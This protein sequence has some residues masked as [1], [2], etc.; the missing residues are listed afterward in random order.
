MKFNYQARTKEGEIKIGI[1]EASSRE[2]ALTILQRAG[3]YVT[4]LKEAKPPLYARQIRIFRAISI[5]DIVLFSRQLAIMFASKVPLLEALRTLATQTANSE[6]R[7]K[8]FDLAKEVEGGSSLSKALSRHPKIFSPFFISIVK[9]GEASGKLAESLTYLADHLEREY[10][11]RNRIRGAMLY[12]ALVLVVIFSVLTLIVFLVVPNFERVIIE[13]G[14]EAPKIT[15]L[16]IA[17]S[18]FFRKNF[19]FI[20]LSLFLLFFIVSRYYK[21]KEGKILFDK[22][23]L[24][25]PELGSL[26]K[27]LYVSRFAENL[28]TLISAGILLPQAL[29]ITAEIVGNSLYKAA[30]LSAKEETKKGIPISSALAMFPKIF[31]PIFIEMASVGEKT[32]TLDTTLMK[33][34]L[35]YRKEME[36]T[37][38]SL[39]GV[40]EPVLIII[41]G[42]VVGGIVASVLLPLYQMLG[43]L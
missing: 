16:V 22:Y 2:A 5:R 7:E 29:E 38:E 15:Q 3:F 12:P 43:P 13:S 14:I 36:R 21:T 27:T 32:G 11:L 23:L 26:L 35:F 10:D 1:V 40:L 31:P 9:S 25:I 19:L 42:L 4:Y 20:V 17:G 33:I 41:L 37:I 18:H 39:L 28:S 24:E 6:L 30:I 34:S 8:I